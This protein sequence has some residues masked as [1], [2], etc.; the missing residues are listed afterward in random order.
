M[1]LND[2]QQRI[3]SATIVV[4]AGLAV[5]FLFLDSDNPQNPTIALPTVWSGRFPG[6]ARRRPSADNR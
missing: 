6:H 2:T 3:R 5:L 1:N 4:L